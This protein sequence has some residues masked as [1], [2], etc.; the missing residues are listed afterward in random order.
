MAL[1]PASASASVNPNQATPDAMP[2]SFQP[3]GYS[4]SD[5][6]NFLSSYKAPV[7]L[8]GTPSNIPPPS[9]DQWSQGIQQSN[10][11]MAD[12]AYQ[13]YWQQW[14][15]NHNPNSGSP[16]TA[17]EPMSYDQFESNS[18]GLIAGTP[19]QIGNTLYPPTPS[20]S[21][22]TGFVDSQG[23]PVTQAG[24]AY[25]PNAPQVDPGFM[26]TPNPPVQNITPETPMIQGP[27]GGWIPDP[28]PTGPVNYSNSPSSGGLSSLLNTG[29]VN[30]TQGTSNM[31]TN[32]LSQISVTPT[33]N[34]PA[35]PD[36]GAT[37]G[38]P[39]GGNLTQGSA[40]PN[41]TT[42][43]QQATAA[44]QFYTDYLN[45]LAQQGGQAAQNAQYVGAQ[46]LQQQA[47]N[48]AQQ[49]VGNYQPTLNS[50]I[51]LAQGV[52]QS[53]IVDALGNLNQQNIATNLSPQTTAGI[54]GAGQF[55][56]TRGA[57][58]LGQT[59]N[60][61]DIATQ[62]QQAQAMQQ[63]YANQLA[64]AGQLGNLASQQQ[65]L[66]LGDVNALATL[67]GQQQTIAQ[68]QQLFPMQQLT[69]ESAL[70]RGYTMPTST[71]SSYTGPIPGAYAASP[72]QQIAGLGALAA[73]VSNTPL[74][75]AIG[76][77][78]SGLGTSLSAML[79][80]NNTGTGGIPASQS[81][82]EGTSTQPLSMPVDTTGAP[83]ST[84]VDSSG[85]AIGTYDSSGAYTPYIQN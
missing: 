24:Y 57:Q 25:N 33:T 56:S 26:M 47:F 65:S 12:P 48:Q 46:P 1:S 52:G 74:G 63:D 42:T 36:I 70:L 82:G 29:A 75:S 80:L 43:Q 71:S 18:S 19:S 60:A 85:N 4:Q 34:S 69:N 39:Q 17:D 50:A 77:G 38:S 23:T 72:L 32:P 55:G 49:N 67:G 59:I 31:A 73:G 3:Q 35:V 27:N 68:N 41:I 76:T 83:G 13:N 40:L 78:L 61:A 44:P 64:A 21:S 16:I 84:A 6:Q 62:A 5:Y 22:P 53:N 58:A 7:S 28:N 2:T 79:G 10:Q 30:Q 11:Q 15:Q 66:G 14:Q 9:Y 81:T 20:T 8:D 45:Q 54:V 37:A 51:N